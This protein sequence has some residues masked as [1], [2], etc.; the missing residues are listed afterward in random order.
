[1]PS[2]HGYDINPVS[3]F[4]LLHPEQRKQEGVLSFFRVL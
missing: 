2:A 4:S 1:M 3:A